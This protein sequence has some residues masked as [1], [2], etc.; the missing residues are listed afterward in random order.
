MLFYCNPCQCPWPV[1]TDVTGTWL[2]FVSE[3]VC[4]TQRNRALREGVYEQ[5]KKN[6]TEKIQ[7]DMQGTGQDPLSTERF[8][9]R[10]Y[11]QFY[12]GDQYVLIHHNG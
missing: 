1:N 10:N 6:P 11:K 9:Q 8:L 5:K 3:S 12:V 4:E 7:E 2:I